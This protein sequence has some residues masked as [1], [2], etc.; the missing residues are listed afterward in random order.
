MTGRYGQLT[1]TSFDTAEHT[2]GWQVKETSADLSP[3]EVQALTSGVRTVF[4]PAQPL[5]AY[6]TP[7]QLERGP[8]RL[9]Y[10]R[11]DR[12]RAGY[13]HTV[14]AG[15]DS[16]G[17]PGNVFAHALLDRAAGERSHRPIEWWRSTGWLCPYGPHAVAEAAL[18]GE[19]PAPGAA[20]TKDSVVRFALDPAAWRLATLFGLLDAVAAAMDGGPPVVLGV[21]SAD[22]A[23]QWIGLV[24]FL[25]SAGTA[26]QLNFSTFDR[27]DQLTLARQS[28]QHVTAVPLDDLEHLP[29]DVV[30]ISEHATLSLGELD[31][32]PH[33]TAE[34]QT[35]AVTP[36]SAMA[37]VVLLDAESARSVLDDIDHYA[38][39]VADTGLH[40]AWPLAMSVAH[41]EAYADALTEAHAVI[42][43]H[44]PRA[45][46]DSVV[47]RT[48]ADVMRD[49]LGASTADAW[50][51]VQDAPDGPAADLATV[52]YLSRAVADRE[53]LS[54][55]GPLPARE[56][57]IERHSAPRELRDAIEPALGAARADG[58]YRVARLADLLLRCGVEDDRVLDALHAD[59]V[60][61]L[62]DSQAA[63]TLLAELRENIGTPTRLALA[64][65][66]LRD[67]GE[68]PAV[69]GDV[70]DWLAE[71]LTAP[72]PQELWRADAW[73]SVWTRA[74]LRGVRTVQRGAS[75]PADRWASLWWLRVSGSARF[76]EVAGNSV[77]HPD[78]L[79]AAVG[80][81]ALPGAVTL[82]TLV[83]APSSAALERLAQAV[84]R[85]NN[86]DVAVACAALRIFDPRTWVEQGYAASHQDAYAALW[87]QAVD[88]VGPSG[89]HHDFA[90]RLATF[91]AV[92]ATA[93]R[94]YP[95]ASALLTAD[96]QVSADAFGQLAALLDNHVLNPMSVLAVAALRFGHNGDE[97]PVAV[98]GIED[99]IWQAAR[100]I[101]TTRRAETVDVGMIAATMAQ[102]L[103]EPGD[104]AVRR[105]R[106][107]VLKLLARRPE[108]QPAPTA[109]TR[110]SR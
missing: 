106:K 95:S 18:P 29:D 6:P 105:H 101:L 27:A 88:T 71:G 53:W 19:P 15:S 52:T 21:E 8:R 5:P 104:G 51:A 68:S 97:L 9:A 11:L 40:P 74:A 108:A 110:W 87:Q 4:R 78:E 36:W 17:R 10:G 67:G 55:P 86:D 100:H 7:E 49:A 99:L 66:L 80:E 25:M 62:A 28:R 64:A 72:P 102:L 84:L 12:H 96:A 94:P 85:T 83:G 69:A 57:R 37:Q 93:G 90:V 26:A 35:I 75:D 45:T 58:P 20:V 38:G 63:P 79:L 81:S 1:Y 47:T 59:V 91:G 61:K 24:S 89:V 70:L 22:S 82:R 92:A 109:R 41:R 46:G 34:G 56:R 43:A 14:P 32:E 60:P 103:G 30:A 73:D 65:A 50:R 3:D 13:W 31:R 23:A 33:R 77:W 16:T 39:Q 98:D 107:T 48:I 76:D 44:S 54:R 42:A 2:G